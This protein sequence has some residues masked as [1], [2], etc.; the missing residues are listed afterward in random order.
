MAAITGE[1]II[2]GAVEP[3]FCHRF[4]FSFYGELLPRL[5]VSRGVRLAKND[6]G[7]VFSS[8]WQKKTWFSVWFCTVCCLMRMHSTVFYHCFGEREESRTDHNA[9]L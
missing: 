9:E 6:F 4:A 2:S 8:V 3:A 7:S 1:H 5:S